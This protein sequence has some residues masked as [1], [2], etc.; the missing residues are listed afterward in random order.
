MLTFLGVMGG[1]L[2]SGPFERTFLSIAQSGNSTLLRFT[3]AVYEIGCAI[4]ALSVIV[5]GDLFGRRVT[6]MLGQAIL[7][8][9]AAL[10]F[11]SYSLT[12]LIIGRIVSTCSSSPTGSF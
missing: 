5:G 8:I 12:Q 10:Q 7:I 6:V 4:G 11:S 9:G 3:V 1:F 2:T